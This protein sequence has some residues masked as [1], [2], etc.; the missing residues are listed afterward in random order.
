MQDLRDQS[1]E[2]PANEQS[3]DDADDEKRGHSSRLRPAATSSES[4]CGAVESSSS[5]APSSPASSSAPATSSPAVSD[6]SPSAAAGSQLLTSTAEGVP[7]RS[8]CRLM[9][10]MAASSAS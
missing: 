1:T 8:S 9:S 3:R 7:D 2:Q 5:S 6:S 10:A 4:S